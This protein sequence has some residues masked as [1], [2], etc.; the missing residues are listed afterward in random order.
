MR[1]MNKIGT[2]IK[3]SLIDNA[4]LDQVAMKCFHGN[5][6][7]AITSLLRNAQPKE[8]YRM[9]AKYHMQQF[10]HYK[11][12]LDNME[13]LDGIRQQKLTIEEEQPQQEEELVC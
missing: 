5:R 10:Q 11:Q 3:L 1:E 4:L 13:D 9:K 6:S 7:E 12:L 8:F 2:S